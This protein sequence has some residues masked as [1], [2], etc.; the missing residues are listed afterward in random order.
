MSASG[1]VVMADD[2]GVPARMAAQRRA[3]RARRLVVILVLVAVAIY[4]GF[5][6]MMAW[7]R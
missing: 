3:V 6:L 7:R 5:I 2:A 4:F 1:S